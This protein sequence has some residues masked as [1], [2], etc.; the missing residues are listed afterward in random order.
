MKPFHLSHTSDLSFDELDALLG[1][2]KAVADRVRTRTPEPT[3]PM[4]D[5]VALWLSTKD[6][7]R[8][9]SS[10]VAA[11]TRLGG[12]VAPYTNLLSSETKEMREPLA[13]LVGCADAMGYRVAFARL[14]TQ[15]QTNEMIGASTNM[16]I[17][18]ALN[19]A[20]HP[21]QSF[22][23]A[24]ALEERTGIGKGKKIVFMGPGRNNV[25]ISLA[26]VAA[27]RGWHFVHSG[28]Q[29]HQIPAERF[30]ELQELARK[31]GG[32]VQ[33]IEDW[34]EAVPDATMVYTDV[35]ASMGEKD[36]AATLKKM[37]AGYKVTQEVM[38][39]AGPQALIGHCLPAEA[40]EIDEHLADVHHPNSI[41]YP[42]AGYRAHT[43]TALL[44]MIVEGKLK[45]KKN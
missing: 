30:A 1:E 40:A 7:F 34:T 32:S 17:V 13:H 21:M 20:G 44:R 24:A 38:D 29:G 26:E 9:A 37:L 39:R 10:I 3:T 14:H 31:G 2:S 27:M 23:D 5:Q 4:R 35:H 43:A 11:T 16:S 19:D 36:Q 18:N 33:Y 12:N 25:T 22:A 45:P 6:S 42:I 15:Q 8:T 41:I 28:P